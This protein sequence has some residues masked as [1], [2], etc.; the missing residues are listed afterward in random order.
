M[1]PFVGG[2]VFP[3]HI[4]SSPDTVD[5]FKNITNQDTWQLIEKGGGEADQQKVHLLSTSQIRRSSAASEKAG[6]QTL[7]RVF[8]VRVTSGSST[9][10][11]NNAVRK[12]IKAAGWMRKRAACAQH[13]GAEYK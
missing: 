8:Q 3:S 9:A 13:N 12:S 11:K 10:L 7:Q 1:V 2:I 4:S 6:D 5:I